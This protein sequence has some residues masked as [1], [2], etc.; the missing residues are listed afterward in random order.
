MRINSVAKGTPAAIDIAVKPLS[1][2]IKLAIQ[3]IRLKRKEKH[4]TPT[5]LSLTY[6][7]LKSIH[8]KKKTITEKANTIKNTKR[9]S[10]LIPVKRQEVKSKTAKE[11]AI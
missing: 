7:L 4:N 9:W 1:L 10:I 11:T 8:S 5:P 2:F 3:N 6:P